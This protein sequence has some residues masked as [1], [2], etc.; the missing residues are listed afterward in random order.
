[1]SMSD[2][3]NKSNELLNRFFEL[4]RRIIGVEDIEIAANALLDEIYKIAPVPM[5]IFRVS[6]EGHLS[7]IQGKGFSNDKLFNL[8]LLEWLEGLVDS[9]IDKGEALFITDGQ[10]EWNFE[11][12]CPFK[13]F[14]LIPLDSNRRIEAILG[15]ADYNGQFL[16]SDMEIS[17]RLLANPL[18]AEMVSLDIYSQLEGLFLS[19]VKALASAVDA[20]HP[21]TRGHSERVTRYAV[22]IGEK[23][24]FGKKE[25]KSLRLSALL[26]DVGKIGISENVLDKHGK[27]NDNEYKQI[28]EHPIIGAK[29][30]GQI[31]NSEKIVPGILEHHER[32]DGKGYPY[33][34]KGRDISLFGRIIAVAD[35]FDAMTSTRS[36]RKALPFQ[37]AIEE[38]VDKS[39][40]QFDPSVVKAFVKAF[41]EQ[42][43]IWQRENIIESTG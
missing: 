2:L 28:K 31:S 19:T 13:S 14:M 42:K 22:A 23:M 12:E 18:I 4:N 39:G 6:A 7:F 8:K 11:K 36:Y 26:H 30:V 21:Y 38:I 41:E 20:K 32:Y 1:M 10:P 25:I 16:S 35:T 27:L 24:D 3:D 5:A 34:K 9:A 40:N 33:G 17:L 37:V 43:D 29:I 15:L